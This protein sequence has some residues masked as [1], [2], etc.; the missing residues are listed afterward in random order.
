MA[1]DGYSQTIWP[2]DVN[3]NGIVN[4]V[5]QLYIGVAYGSNVSD[6]TNVLTGV[7]VAHEKVLKYPAPAVLLD[8]FGDNSVD[9][10]LL[11]WTSDIDNWLT[12]RSELS[13]NIY[14]ALDEAGIGIPFPQRDL[15][16]TSWNTEITP[17]QIADVATNK[18]SKDPGSKTGMDSS[19]ADQESDSD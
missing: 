6:V 7:L 15:H 16:I 10:R 5:D 12:T 2:G 8:G 19:N 14:N 17:S 13:A 18:A 3:N 9:F 11:I 4:G 1:L